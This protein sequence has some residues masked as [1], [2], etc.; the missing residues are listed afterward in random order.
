VVEGNIKRSNE[1]QRT[2]KGLQFRKWNY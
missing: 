1:L 2:A